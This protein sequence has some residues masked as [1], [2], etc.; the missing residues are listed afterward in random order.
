MKWIRP[1]SRTDMLVT[2]CLLLTA[3]IL[4]VVKGH[5]EEQG[6]R[7]KVP[8]SSLAAL[9]LNGSVTPD[10]GVALTCDL[11]AGPP[12]A[13]AI[14]PAAFQLTRISDEMEEQT[15]APWTSAK[16][17]KLSWTDAHVMGGRAYRYW[18]SYASDVNL[19]SNSI[20]LWIPEKIEKGVPLPSTHERLE[21]EAVGRDILGV[22]HCYALRAKANHPGVKFVW[23][24]LTPTVGPL[25][26]QHKERALIRSEDLPGYSFSGWQVEASLGE[27]RAIAFYLPPILKMSMVEPDQPTQEEIKALTSKQGQAEIRKLVRSAF[28]PKNPSDMERY[29]VGSLL[30]QVGKPALSEIRSWF[31]EVE[32]E[33][34]RSELLTL[35][36]NI[37]G[38]YTIETLYPKILDTGP[39]LLQ[40]QMVEI[41]CGSERG[42]SETAT[43]RLLKIA[44]NPNPMVRASAVTALGFK[45]TPNAVP[46]L[47]K[48]CETEQSHTL[49]FEA[50]VSLRRIL[51]KKRPIAKALPEW[52]QRSPAE[53]DYVRARELL[54]KV[55]ETLKDPKAAKRKQTLAGM[56]GGLLDAEVEF[57]PSD[58]EGF[59]LWVQTESPLADLC[60]LGP[61]ANPIVAEEL[62]Q[63]EHP[64]IHVGML[65]WLYW[66][67]SGDGFP[68]AVTEQFAQKFFQGDK[69]QR[70]KAF[71]RYCEIRT[72]WRRSIGTDHYLKLAQGMKTPADR[73]GALEEAANH[74]WSYI[75]STEPVEKL[76]ARVKA[77]PSKGI[78]SI[79]A[80]FSED[81][82]WLLVKGSDLSWR[83]YKIEEQEGRKTLKPVWKKL[84]SKPLH[85]S[86]NQNFYATTGLLV[87]QGNDD[88]GNPCNFAW[89]LTDGERVE[90]PSGSVS[91]DGT[92]CARGNG[93]RVELL[94]MKSGKLLRTLTEHQAVAGYSGSWFYSPQ[95]DLLVT[96]DRDD[97]QILWDVKSG[98]KIAELSNVS[99]FSLDGKALVGRSEDGLV[100]YDGNDGKELARFDFTGEDVDFAISNDGF[101][102]ATNGPDL[103]LFSLKASKRLWH[104]ERSSPMPGTV[105]FAN[106]GKLVFTLG[107]SV[108][109]RDTATGKEALAVAAND[110][111]A[112]MEGPEVKLSQNGKCA[113]RWMPDKLDLL[114]LNGFKVAPV[115]NP[116]DGVQNVAYSPELDV[117]ANLT[118]KL[119][120]LWEVRT[121]KV[122]G[123]D[124]VEPIGEVPAPSGSYEAQAVR[125]LMLIQEGNDPVG[126]LAR[127]LFPWT[128]QL[129][130]NR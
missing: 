130:G 35:M 28:D 80:E 15:H 68:R 118:P 57:K 56:E 36:S 99:I 93:T 81:G 59:N 24:A 1:F 42:Q 14:V 29:K 46:Y 23:K 18:V 72:W 105:R 13:P 10:G 127:E 122:L 66:M 64:R 34:T 71:E 107:I 63:A 69:D 128:E 97:S 44:E 119:V 41:A 115:H 50:A 39:A 58:P 26:S 65:N 54:P 5:A 86:W 40:R 70:K 96:K 76:I 47:K 87:T 90:V 104:A 78:F 112:L 74:T 100:V 12:G 16:G 77:V 84:L 92:L 108:S 52:E 129:R 48:L 82:A 67:C 121:G 120:E 27:Q 37:D 103:S 75:K 33:G 124:S 95:G 43:S 106:D 49:R 25:L 6:A 60:V 117:A 17:G 116:R 123:S 114:D 88:Q 83:L 111:E 91:P 73:F 4:P 110:Q 125:L 98:R 126:E 22:R 101:L 89:R 11:V 9:Y 79:A 51:T 113:L 102:A 32:S 53:E 19:A 3:L 7:R 94:E 55:W 2:S 20:V 62:A 85:G 31:E 61:A 21:V 30:S 8:A 109:V 38:N 45:G